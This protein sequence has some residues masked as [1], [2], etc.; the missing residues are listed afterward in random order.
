MGERQIKT[1][2]IRKCPDCEKMMIAIEED[3]IEKF[4]CPGCGKIIPRCERLLPRKNLQ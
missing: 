3:G 1:K 2:Q 4:K